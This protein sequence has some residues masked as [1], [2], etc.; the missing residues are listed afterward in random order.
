MAARKTCY[1]S[2][3][4]DGQEIRYESPGSLLAQACKYFDW[5]DNNPWYKG[6]LIRSGTRAG[7]VIE[8]PVARPYTVEGLCVFCGISMKTFRQYETDA[9]LCEVAGHLRTVIR[10]QQIE[11]DLIGIYDTAI[12]LKIPDTLKEEEETQSRGLT[13][14]VL[15]QE[16]KEQLL[17]LKESLIK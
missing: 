2:R 9:A 10:Q 5:C 1:T 13:I 7:E 12:L 15:S 11:G 8:V 17:K 14:N 6:E 3:G 16:T 4:K